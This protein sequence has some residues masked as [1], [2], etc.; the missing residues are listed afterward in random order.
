MDI[1]PHR[2]VHSLINTVAVDAIVCSLINTVAVDAIVGSLREYPQ[3]V[4]VHQLSYAS[5]I[6]DNQEPGQ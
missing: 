1:N 6:Q 4:F 5:V 3:K 2:P